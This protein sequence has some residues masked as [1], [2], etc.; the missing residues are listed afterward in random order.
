MSV[1]VLIE[2]STD[3]N[4]PETKIKIV[5]SE[6]AAQK[7]VNETGK[8]G[9]FSSPCPEIERNWHHTFRTAYEMPVGWRR[10]SKKRLDDLAWEQGSSSHRLTANDILVNLAWSK[11]IREISPKDI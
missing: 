6:I 10:P 9:R 5:Y 4:R 1:F 8:S 7:F 11:K 3:R 2:Q